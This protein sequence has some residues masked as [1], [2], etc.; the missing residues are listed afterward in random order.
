MSQFFDLAGHGAEPIRYEVR[1][2][3][4]RRTMSIEVHPD[5]RVVVRVPARC[6]GGEV[7]AWVQSRARWIERTLARLRRRGPAAVSLRY[8]NGEAHRYLGCAYPLRIERGERPGISLAA[9]EMVVRL[10]NGGPDPGA[11]CALL[12]AWYFARAAE[13]FPAILRERHAAFF[14][15]RGHPL[16]ALSVKLLRRRWGSMSAR[17]RMS[18]NADLIRSPREGIELVVVHELCHLEVPYHDA[19]FYRLLGQALPDWK[20]RKRLLLAP[21]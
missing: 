7:A 15:R 8:V 1:A 17:G 20:E 5:S 21:A 13:L 4:R 14:A 18:L 16:P 19:A 9:N 12:R 6:P 11:V 10:R 3:A 2:S